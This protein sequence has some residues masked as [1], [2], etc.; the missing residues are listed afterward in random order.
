MLKIIKKHYGESEQEDVVAEVL[1]ATKCEDFSALLADKGWEKAVEKYR[2]IKM[3]ED[4]DKN[5]KLMYE[6]WK[7]QQQQKQ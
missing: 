4:R 3:F 7:Q 2:K 5:T 6:K 1:R